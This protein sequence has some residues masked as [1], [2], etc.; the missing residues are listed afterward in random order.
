MSN[1][2]QRIPS[3][4]N[5]QG[6]RSSAHSAGLTEELTAVLKLIATQNAK[7]RDAESRAAQAGHERTS[8]SAARSPATW[9]HSAAIDRIQDEIGALSERFADAGPNASG[10]DEPFERNVKQATPKV[11]KPSPDDEPWDPATAEALTRVYEAAALGVEATT[12]GDVTTTPPAQVGDG[13]A[14]ANQTKRDWLEERF[15]D[16]AAKLES[17]LAER[18][19]NNPAQHLDNR[20]EHLEARICEALEGLVTRSDIEHLRPD[21]AKFETVADQLDRTAVQLSR[22]DTIEGNIEAVLNRLTNERIVKE[23][24]ESHGTVDIQA[25]ADATANNIVARLSEMGLGQVD[26]KE[27]AEIR[28]SI[29][30]LIEER[31]HH[32]EQ[33]VAILDTLQQAMIGVIDR[34]DAL[35]QSSNGIAEF[36]DPL[37]AYPD[38]LSDSETEYDEPVG[39]PIPPYTGNSERDSD[40]PRSASPHYAVPS[41]AD[42]PAP[43]G[44]ERLPAQSG[45]DPF[46]DSDE[47]AFREGD[48][49]SLSPVDRI[50]QELIADAKRARQQA[51]EQAAKS[52]MAGIVDKIQKTAGTRTKRGVE[53]NHEP[54]VEAPPSKST[55]RA[56]NAAPAANGALF[57][58]RRKLLVGAVIILFATAG[59]LMMLRATKMEAPK[60][61][62]ASIEQNT[63]AAPFSAPEASALNERS[64]EADH[65]Q[66]RVEDPASVPDQTGELESKPLE[67]DAPMS[68]PARPVASNLHGVQIQ[69]SA[70]GL[71]P[72]Q[73][74][75]LGEKQ[76]MAQLSAKLGEAAAHAV[77]A[78]LF[79]DSGTNMGAV[80]SVTEVDAESATSGMAKRTPLNLPP[81]TVGP[82][83]LRM[84][85]ANGDASAE[86]EVG[87]RMA[88][89]NGTDQNFKEAARWY[90]RSAAQGFAQAQYRLGTFYERG[91]GMKRD[92]ARAKIWYQRAAENGNVKAM[93]NLAVLSTGED[94]GTPDY[95]TAAKWFSEAAERGLADSQYNLGVLHENGLGTPKD[96]RLAYLYFSL[97]Q[98][99]G[100]KEAKR[101]LETLRPQL[102]TDQLQ[103][104]EGMVQSWRRTP[105]DR[106]ANDARA[107]GEDWKSRADV[108]Y[109]G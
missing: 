105:T 56:K 14:E 67:Y 3:P 39:Q 55:K 34:V 86:F 58:R 79:P 5:Q 18:H 21:H 104:A 10:F 91:L 22:L 36:D 57:G 2:E 7:A 103:V 4:V 50:R 95:K 64:S 49:A 51:S 61:P 80:M 94:A 44:L 73:I 65:A 101:R 89:G 106:L 87:A 26:S 37:P 35:A 47:A 63:G 82:M 100:D 30:L 24:E 9:D 74:A 88:E 33:S 107:A 8:E 46:D 38:Q 28:Q 41:F 25:V 48:L 66:H 13:T 109:G 68:D 31:R 60:A 53:A 85:A 99:S 16:I 42:E 102:Q 108:G 23:G 98:K 11:T 17:S 75:Q 93:H 32:D 15:A 6:G 97:A 62:A 81:A 90:Q 40:A 78:A 1:R 59:A 70:R 45:T 20:L 72:D 43:S 54:N 69:N 83:S 29:D 71:T 92:L 76:A 96:L 84:A 12:R 77:P 52:T 27:L 19:E